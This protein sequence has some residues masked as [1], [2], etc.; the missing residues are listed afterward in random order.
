LQSF[1]ILFRFDKENSICDL[2]FF[3]Y[4]YSFLF[5][6]YIEYRGLE[7]FFQN[8][9]NFQRQ[10][11]REKVN[12]RRRTNIRRYTH[13]VSAATANDASGH[14]TNDAA[15]WFISAPMMPPHMMNMM[16]QV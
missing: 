4:F 3:Y 2:L 16:N 6:C 14:A 5:F 15:I 9:T 11:E 12:C 1:S 8:K 7:V 13:V 10:T